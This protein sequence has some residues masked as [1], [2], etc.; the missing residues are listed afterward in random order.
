MARASRLVGSVAEVWEAALEASVVEAI[1]A[2][3]E[4]ARLADLGACRLQ[5]DLAEGLEV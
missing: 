2:A 1:L 3:S 4:E 5:V